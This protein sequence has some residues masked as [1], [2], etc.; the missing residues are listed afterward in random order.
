MRLPIIEGDNCTGRYLMRRLSEEGHVVDHTVDGEVGHATAL[1]GTRDALVA[2]RDLPALDG[3]A[4]V[5]GLRGS[6]APRRC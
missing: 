1:K 2:D 4:L 6:S 5:R 3:L